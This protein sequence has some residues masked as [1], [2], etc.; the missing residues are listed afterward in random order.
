M[1][2]AIRFLER[3]GEGAIAFAR[4]SGTGP[5]I[6][7]LSG[8][9][10]DMTGTKA[11]RLAALAAE[12]G[13]AF[14]RFDYRGH[15]RSSGRFE[16]CTVGD[17]LDDTLAILDRVVEGPFVLVGSSLGGWLALRAGE[18]RIDRLVG[19]VLVAPAPDFPRRLVLPA[20]S[21][22][23]RR[24]LE[25]AGVV[26]LPSDH[27]EPIPFTRRFLEESIDHEVLGRD[28]P[29]SCP[30]HILHGRRDADVPLSLSLELV[31]R[32]VAAK[33][34]LE[35]IADGDHRLSRETDLVRLCAAVT[36][37]RALARGEPPPVG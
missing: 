22:E 15:G 10:S 6:V 37:V 23:Q 28:L 32:L 5:E 36:R 24:M 27:C 11:S 1:E 29:F 17:W 2:P 18:E 3:D 20:L 21:P 33:I 19:L 12:R 26:A 9:R 8:L 13:W 35:V 30:V 34:T 14:T 7:F 31:A 25:Q 16:E 4:E